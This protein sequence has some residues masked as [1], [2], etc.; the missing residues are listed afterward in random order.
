M[1]D[2]LVRGVIVT[3]FGIATTALTAIGLVYLEL[4]YDCAIYG[5]VYG[6]V[7]PFGAMLSGCLAASGYYLG[8]RLVNYRPGRLFF[9]NM[10]AVSGGNFFLIYW[11]KYSLLKV[12]GEPVSKWM[13]FAD[14]LRFAL[15]HTAF[16]LGH[17]PDDKYV[18]GVGGYAY[19]AVLILGFACGGWIM[20]RL[21]QSAAY[22]EACSLYMQKQGSQTRYFVKRDD[23]AGCSAAFKSEA[24]R[25]QMRKAVDLHSRAGLREEDGTTGYF[26]RV[27]F[28]HCKRCGNQWLKLAARER[29][30]NSWNRMSDFRYSTCC[31]ERIDAIEKLAGARY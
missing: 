12:D 5:F 27:E 23:L 13:T 25:G 21:A 24:E 29:V 4:R 28:M 16:T 26:L 11:L 19:A 18:L 9:V 20:F 31:G 3:L 8:S 22:C 30:N 15:T 10:L 14:Y 17:S 7:I 1:I 6:F 2:K